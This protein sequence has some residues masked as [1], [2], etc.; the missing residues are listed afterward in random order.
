MGEANTLAYYVTTTIT[1]VE[2]FIGQ[3]PSVCHKTYFLPPSCLEK[4]SWGVS[5]CGRIF[6]LY[7]QLEQFA[8]P[9]LPLLVILD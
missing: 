7:T 9:L 8:L 5:L 6:V 1:A 2:S 4:V 3:A